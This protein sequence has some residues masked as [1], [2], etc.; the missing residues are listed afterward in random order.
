MFDNIKTG[1]ELEIYNCTF[2]ATVEMT[3]CLIESLNVDKSHFD[4]LNV[5]NIATHTYLTFED[6]SPEK[7]DEKAEGS[8]EDQIVVIGGDEPSTNNPFIHRKRKFKSAIVEADD[9]KSVIKFKLHRLLPSM[10]T[11]CNYC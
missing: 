3:N 5:D 2:E 6:L 1:Y 9:R 4:N 7:F 11:F 10:A 8:V